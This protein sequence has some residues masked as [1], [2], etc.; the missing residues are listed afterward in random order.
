MRQHS[1]SPPAELGSKKVHTITRDHAARATEDGSGAIIVIE[2][3]DRVGHPGK[4]VRR[5]RRAAILDKIIHNGHN[6]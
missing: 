5:A 6:R 2:K 3:N 4:T 1:M